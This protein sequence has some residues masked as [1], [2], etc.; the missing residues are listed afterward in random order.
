MNE[1]TWRVERVEEVDSTNTTLVARA[2]EGE[3]E[4]LVLRADH[5]SGGRGRLGRSWEASPGS[6]LLCS[7]L[8]RPHLEAER[9]QWAVVAVALSTRAALARVGV[10]SDLKWPNDVLVD[11]RKVAGVL[12]EYVSAP[13]ESAI[14]VGLGVNVTEHPPGV[15][16]TDIARVR[17]EAPTPDDFLDVVLDEL[18]RRRGLLDT[19]RGLTQLAE[20]YR[21][22]LVTL[23][24]RV[25]VHERSRE[26]EGLAYDVDD[27]GHLLVHTDHGERRVVAGDVVH[28]R[29]VIS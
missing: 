22:A 8:L 3:A 18:G 9:L 16:A 19:P 25:R 28:V 27:A 17:G 4:G 23:G 21:E 7:I 5:Q 13:S 15:G 2:R 11:S 6:A 1:Y 29:A 26:W 20:E 24:Q 10:S 14:V 12:A